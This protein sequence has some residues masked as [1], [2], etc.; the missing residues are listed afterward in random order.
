MAD[1]SIKI[2][3]YKEN[4]EI[5][6][7][8]Y[9]QYK[10]N[11]NLFERTGMFLYPETKKVYELITRYCRDFVVNH[12]QYPKFKWKPKIIDIGCGGGFGSNI[13]SQEGEYIWGIDKDQKSIAFAK[14]LFSRHR[15]NIY[16]NPEMSFD[17]IDVLTEEREIQVFDIVACVEMIEHVEDYNKV[18]EFIKKRCKKDKKG[19]YQEP[20]DSTKVF[21]STHNRNNVHSKKDSPTTEKHVREWSPDEL[22]AILTKNFKYVTI[23][24]IDGNLKELNMDEPTMVFK[25][26]VPII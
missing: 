20:P 2:E 5:D 19:I 24:D 10:T 8:G 9:G 21:I 12:P 15:N 14:E 26:E 11:L 4:K 1:E 3:N 13:L 18:L 6:Y 23:M 22:Y 17:V 16:F 25:C 7:T